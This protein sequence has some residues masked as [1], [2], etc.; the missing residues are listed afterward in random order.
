VS[1]VRGSV[2]PGFEPVRDAFQRVI[3]D[4]V[5]GAAFSVYRRGVPL[6]WLCGGRADPGAGAPWRPDTLV[7]LFSGTKGIAATVA[8]MLMAHGLLDPDRPVCEYWPEFGAAGKRGVRVH[9]VLAHSAGLPYVDPEPPDRLDNAANAAALAAQAPLWPPGE[10]VAYHALTYGYLVAELGRRVT[11]RSI[12]TL[13]REVLARPHGLD[14]HLGAAPELDGR[15]ARVAAAPDYRIST[16]LTDPSRRATVQRIYG[17]V[18]F[19]ELANSVDFRRAQLAAAS[20]VGTADSMA[21]LYDLIAAGAV[22]DPERLRTATRT[23][24][25]GLDAIN[26]RPVRFGLGYELDDPIGT[27][28]PA[29][30]TRRRGAFGHSGAGGGRHGAWPEHGLGFS[31]TTN[32]LRS[33][34][35]DSRANTLLDALWHA[36][37]GR[38]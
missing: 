6:V 8:A 10:R 28:G 21:R 3:D 26:D 18:P 9:H 12:G 22:L 16:F 7:V 4:A 37:D 15:L 38:C 32:E 17:P 14:L 13:V 24:S 11:G 1:A 34:D 2:A 5:G 27:Y 35:T 33:E 30:A 29:A 19:D 31:F 25:E 36:L 20:A 23:W